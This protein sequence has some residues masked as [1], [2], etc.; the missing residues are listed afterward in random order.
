MNVR[1]R[2]S[3][4]VSKPNGVAKRP[5]LA[6]NQGR[7]FVRFAGQRIVPST[8]YGRT[9]SPRTVLASSSTTPAT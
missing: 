2:S 9:W 6:S 4:G 7:S 1:M 3:S 5:A 8:S